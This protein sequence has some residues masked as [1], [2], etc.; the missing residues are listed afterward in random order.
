MGFMRPA[1]DESFPSGP[2]GGSAAPGD[3]NTSPPDKVIDISI[4]SNDP[5]IKT[6][7]PR[8]D[9]APQGGKTIIAF[10]DVRF[11]WG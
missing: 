1:H 11:G 8:V 4:N 9:T 5:V 10:A 6:G 3:S 2:R 7:M